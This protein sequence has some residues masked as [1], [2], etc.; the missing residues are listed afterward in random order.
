[1][2]ITSFGCHEDQVREASTHLA[3]CLA[4]P[5]FRVLKTVEYLVSGRKIYTVNH[6][7]HLWRVS[8]TDSLCEILLVFGCVQ[9]RKAS[10]LE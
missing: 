1:M 2:L 7:K 6:G 10:T 3:Q 5:G 8:C 9:V 4:C